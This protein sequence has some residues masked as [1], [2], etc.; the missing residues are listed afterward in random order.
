MSEIYIGRDGQQSGPFT[1]ETVRAMLAAGD[2]AA[3]DLAWRE[4][5]ADWLPVSQVLAG[6]SS[7]APLLA[8][9]RAAA[10]A[11]AG[12]HPGFLVRCAGYLIDTLVTTA[13]G[14]VVGG[15][16]GL[17]LG[18]LGQTD[19]V[20]FSG[21]GAGSGF[22][23]SWLYFALMES[24][25]RQATLGKMACNF[26]VTDMD[27]GRISFGRASVRY[28]GM[29]LSGLLLGIGFLLCIWTERRQCLHDMLAGC[30]MYRR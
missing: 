25:A 4:G 6:A 28:F 26:V 12:E 30:L 27:G 16:M 3:T 9:P 21:F 11:A 13:L 23:V 8:A 20:V 19:T 7:P 10:P 14:F 2:I 15:V 24:S 22:I 18:G 29:F 1:E 5:L 17:L